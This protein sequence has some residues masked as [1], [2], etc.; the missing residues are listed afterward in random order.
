MASSTAANQV[1]RHVQV[2][3]ATLAERDGTET[4]E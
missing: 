3:Q 1:A 4:G 2:L